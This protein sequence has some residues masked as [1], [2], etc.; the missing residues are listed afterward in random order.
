MRP[1]DGGPFEADP[2]EVWR[3]F[4]SRLPPLPGDAVQTLAR[5]H[6]R[7]GPRRDDAAAAGDRGR[8]LRR[9]LGRGWRNRTSGRAPTS[10]GSASSSSPR[11][12]AHSTPWSRTPG[13]GSP[14]GQDASSRPSAP[15]MSST[16]TGRASMPTSSNWASSPDATRRPG[17]AIST[18]CAAAAPP[19]LRRERRPRT[20][21]TRHPCTADLSPARRR[22]CSRASSP[23]RPGR[24]MPRCSAD[25]CS[26][27]WRGMSL[28]DGLVLQIHAGAWRDHNPTVAARFGPDKG[29]DIPT[30]G[31]LRE[32]ASSR[33]WT[34][35]ATR[36]GSR[37]SSTPWTRP[38]TAASSPRSPGTTRR[39]GSDLPWWFYDSP[40][41]IRRFYQSVVETAGFANTVGFNDDA[42]SLLTHPRPPRRG[43]A[44]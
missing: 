22:I 3:A 41:G 6:A 16:R 43:P 17:R 39:C 9:D 33:S 25:R 37:S 4:A 36:P 8:R 30:G 31:G 32:R 1:L 14:A 35:S 15:T 29:A 11:P 24:A 28:D 10:S 19:S 2:R 26:S 27:R 44:A 42:R 23:G 40:E 20:T 21:G 13:S 38:P 18:R 5:L 12:K 7:R 34:G